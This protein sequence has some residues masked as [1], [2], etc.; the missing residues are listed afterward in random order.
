MSNQSAVKD[1][2]KDESMLI[3]KKMLDGWYKEIG[4]AREGG[5]P[6]V[7]SFV[8]GNLTE[9]IL[10]FDCVAV[11]PEIN[12]LHSGMK[13]MSDG[14]ILEAERRGH[15]EDVCTYVKCDLGMFLG[16]NLGPYGKIPPPD[17]LLLSY[18]GCFTFLKWFEALKKLYNCPVV[19][20][21]TPYQDQGVITPDMVDYLVGQFKSDLIPA[22]EKISGKKF[23]IDRLRSLL[24]E[25]RRA[26]ED[27]VYCFESAKNIPSP[28][29]GFFAGVY[30]VGPIFTA[31]RGTPEC[32]EYYRAARREIEYRVANKLGPMTPA[33]TMEK[34]KFRL[35][36]D[37][38][39]NWT[40]FRDFWKVFYEEG[41]VFVASTYTKVG[42]L[43]DTGF[44]HDPDQ[45]LKTMAEY[46]LNV[47]TNNSLPVRTKLMENYIRDYHADGFVFHS[48][49]S[50][51]SFSAGMLAML[52]E[53]EQRTGLPGCFIESDLV[54]SRYFSY[55][56]IKNRVE[57]YLQMVEQK[58]G[59]RG[60]V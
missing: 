23:D 55:A 18:T 30:Y 26:E 21:H 33:G 40:D 46:C 22:L 45:P 39:P 3:Q 27:L 31:F 2:V 44:R 7:Y 15:S 38:T 50:C 1:V 37:G 13:K 4:R 8:P 24:Q 51:N 19:M 54:D 43:Y 57:S 14:F 25:S 58:K 35:V 28:I 48:I 53:L 10:S 60:A 52:R 6:V 34:E 32:T 29:D 16:G 42:G 59:D 11:L 49:K 17:L 47:Y 41:A 36:I 9:F 5:K 20:V 56:N 12:A